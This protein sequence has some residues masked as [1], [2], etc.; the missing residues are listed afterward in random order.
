MNDW[1]AGESNEVCMTIGILSG[2]SIMCKNTCTSVIG[3]III[4]LF[5]MDIHL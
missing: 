2:S 5:V 3:C 4:K 1:W